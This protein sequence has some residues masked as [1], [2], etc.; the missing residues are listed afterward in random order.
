MSGL[1]LRLAGP[2]QSWGERGVF[3]HRDTA[4]FPTRS[5]LIG[6]FAAAQGRTREHA[7]A[8]YPHLPGTPSHRDLRFTLRIDRPGRLH[9][10]F[11]TVG[12]G[13]PRQHTL[14]TSASGHRPETASTLISHRDYLADAVFTVAVHGPPALLD[15]IADTLTAPHFAPYLGRRACLPDEPLLLRHPAADPLT[16]LREHVPLSLARPPHPDTTHV[17]VTFVWEHPPDTTTPPDREST[18]EPADFTTGGRRHL[19]RPQWLTTEHLPA[20]LYA[21]P[22]P[23]DTLTDYVLSEPP[24]PPPR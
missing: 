8:P 6:M 18:S 12:G 23:I 11:H 10:D 14:R 9:R 4:A 15:H 16:E 20:T 13:Y 22:R 17:P 21:G 5:A 1:I 7:L 3:H 24:C 19:P 2:L